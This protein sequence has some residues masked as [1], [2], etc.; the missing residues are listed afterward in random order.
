MPAVCSEWQGLQP[1]KHN[2][3]I[4]RVAAGQSGST[5][6]QLMVQNIRCDAQTEHALHAKCRKRAA[7]QQSCWRQ[8]M[9]R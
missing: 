2:L 9:A 5:Q 3:N 1:V 8:R 6:R 4:Y 7:Q